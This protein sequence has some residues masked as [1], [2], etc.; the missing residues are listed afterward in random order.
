MAKKSKTTSDSSFACG[1]LRYVPHIPLNVPQPFPLSH[2]PKTSSIAA[3]RKSESIN[4]SAR[5]DRCIILHQCA[6][7]RMHEWIFGKTIMKYEVYNKSNLVKL[8]YGGGKVLAHLGWE[9]ITRWKANKNTAFF[10]MLIYSNWSCRQQRVRRQCK[11]LVFSEA[12]QLCSLATKG[13]DSCFVP[14]RICFGPSVLPGKFHANLRHL[15]LPP[16]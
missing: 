4:F 10:E 9:M 2:S 8:A 7:A 3:I 1:F 16:D 13:L 15:Q 12:L 14:F 5:Q 11:D 6:S